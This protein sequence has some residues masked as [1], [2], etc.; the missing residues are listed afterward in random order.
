MDVTQ[1]EMAQLKVTIAKSALSD[2]REIRQYYIEQDAPNIGTKY[3]V[4][5]F[6][7]LEKLKKH[8]KI[9]RVVLEFYK[10]SIRE[11]I[12]SPFRIVY[13]LKTEEVVIIRIWRSER[14]LVLSP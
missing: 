5:V 3:I 7:H 14:E 1:L 6:E 13:L 12:H 2:L 8:P 10:E 4:E 9:G 11:I